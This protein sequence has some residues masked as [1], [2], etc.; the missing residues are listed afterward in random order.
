MVGALLL[1][2]LFVLFLL[3]MMIGSVYIP[4]SS[5]LNPGGAYREILQIIRLPQAVGAIIIGIDLAVAG[6]VMQSIFKNPLADPYI[7]G[8]SSGAVLGVV[9]SLFV[10][11][12]AAQFNRFSIYLQ[13]LFGFLGALFATF[14]VIGFGRKRTG[15]TL[16]L[17]GITVSIFFA[18][19][20]TIA[21]SYLLTRNAS[22]FSI[23]MLLFG[24]LGSLNWSY[25]ILIIAASTP[26]LLFL[27][28]SAKK[29][30]LIMMGDELANSAGINSDRF[31]I[32]MLL[33]SSV[34][35]SL[36]LSFTGIIGFVGLIAPH[37]ARFLI[38]GVDNSKVLPV[39][40]L[41]GAA[42]LLFANFASKALIP[43]TVIPITAITSLVGAPVLIYFIV[44]GDYSGRQY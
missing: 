36:A 42:I 11:S 43:E 34:L 29:L 33:G 10:G 16:I 12:F 25:D 26:V 39:C 40:G 22:S 13:P 37:I 3:N 18:S 5:V 41:A 30:N 17:A 14:L 38:G 9:G 2:L 27:F 21:E 6:A 7:T 20:V 24:S 23:F 15:L 8:T 4:F 1:I 19:L 28:S 31:R 35:T 32:V 44:R